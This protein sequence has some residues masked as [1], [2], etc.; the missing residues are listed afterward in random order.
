MAHFAA[1]A[2]QAQS[3]PRTIVLRLD[4]PLSKS[5]GGEIRGPYVWDAIGSPDN[6]DLPNE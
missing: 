1:G 5:E 2:K 6:L 3:D 4:V